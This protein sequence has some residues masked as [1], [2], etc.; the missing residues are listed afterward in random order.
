M[1]EREIKVMEDEAHVPLDVSKIPTHYWR[2]SFASQKMKTSFFN[3]ALVE[4]TTKLARDLNTSDT[5][6]NK[7]LTCSSNASAYLE[8]NN[9]LNGLPFSGFKC[10]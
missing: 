4:P 6:H 2:F 1:L 9:P 3:Y 7:Q 8:P 10:M 5:Q